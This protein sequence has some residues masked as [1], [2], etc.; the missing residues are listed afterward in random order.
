MP[1]S[2]R[3]PST[4]RAVRSTTGRIDAFTAAETVR[5]SRPYVPV[6][7]WPAQTGSPRS[8]ARAAT[9]RSCSG[10]STEN[11]PLTASAVQPAACEPVERGV[12]AVGIEAAGRVEEG[13]LGVQDAAGRELEVADLRALAREAQL[14]LD[15]DAD[16]ADARDVALEQRV[17]GLR[18]RVRDELDA[19]AVVLE[20]VEQRAQRG[21]DAL[22]DARRPRCGSSARPRA[23][24]ASAAAG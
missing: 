7:S 2:R 10:V 4:T 18:R 5:V 6:S 11:A 14:R 24:A 1:A 23:R 3:T 15:A 17:H 8:R 21:G 12:D 19:V 16:H 20:V 9:T 22:G 13:V